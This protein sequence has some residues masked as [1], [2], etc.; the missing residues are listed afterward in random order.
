MHESLLLRRGANYRS[1]AIA[2]ALAVVN[3]ALWSMGESKASV[4]EAVALFT[5]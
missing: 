3:F 5:K 2:A 4:V 1:H